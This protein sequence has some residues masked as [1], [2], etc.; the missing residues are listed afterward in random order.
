M[1]LIVFTASISPFDAFLIIAFCFC[2]G[3]RVPADLLAPS[4]HR[5]LS[6]SDY[7]SA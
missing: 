1:R 4:A 2:S 6:T 7:R 3:R 5:F